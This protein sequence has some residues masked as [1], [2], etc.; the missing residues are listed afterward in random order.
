M[1]IQDIKGNWA[2]TKAK[3]KQKWSILTDDDLQYVLGKEEELLGKI[4]KRT[5][6]LREVVEK[7]F[8]KACAAWRA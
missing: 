8:K 2:I 1:N 6:A 3:L 7:E 4:Q 5:G